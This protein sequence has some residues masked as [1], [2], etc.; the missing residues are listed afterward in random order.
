M[1]FVDIESTAYAKN[2]RSCEFWLRGAGHGIVESPKHSLAP[3]STCLYHLQ[4]II[5]VFKL[6]VVGV[7]VLCRY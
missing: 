7:K 3:N 5:V 6:L 1:K 2:K 4:V